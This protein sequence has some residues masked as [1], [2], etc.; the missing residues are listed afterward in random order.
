MIQVIINIILS[1]LIGSVSGSIVLGKLRGIDNRK[2]GSRNAGGTNAFRSRGAKF[3]S[4]VLFIDIVKGYIG[5]RSEN[6]F[7]KDLKPYL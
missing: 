3:A 5:P 7:Y 6:V 1:Y 4:L 2:M